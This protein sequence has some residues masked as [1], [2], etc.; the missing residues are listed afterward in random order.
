MENRQKDEARFV[1]SYEEANNFS[2]KH[3]K[4]NVIL[5]RRLVDLGKN[6][7]SFCIYNQKR[8][9]TYRETLPVT[10]FSS[11]QK[12]KHPSRFIQ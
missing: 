11:D 7:D 9:R 10:I 6:D 4:M 2:E 8:R 1:V 12:Q 5:I 3:G